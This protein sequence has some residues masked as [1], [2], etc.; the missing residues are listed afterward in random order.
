MPT[1][2]RYRLRISWP[3]GLPPTGSSS[4][5]V[6]SAADV[7]DGSFD[8]AE[9]ADRVVF[10]GVTDPTLGD[11]VATPISKG[12][13]DPG[14]MVQAAAFHT[15]ASRQFVAEPSTPATLVWVAVLTLLVALAVQFLPLP[16]AGLSSAVLLVVAVLG[17]ILRAADGTPLHS[18]YP[19]MAVALAIPLSGGLRYFT[20]T[21]ARRRVAA[22]FARYV[23]P[24]VAE[25]LTR[26]GRLDEVAEGQRLD[27]SVF[28]CDLR[29]FTPLSAS[30]EPT[31][32]NRILSRYYEYVSAAVLAE[33]G[34]IIQYVGDEVFAVFGAPLARE[35]HASA[36]LRVAFAVQAGRTELER[37]LQDDGL[38]M[39]EFGIGINSGEV[40]AV[41][42]GST[43]RRQYAVVGDTVNVGA[44][45]C[46]EAREGQV[47]AADRAVDAAPPLPGGEPYHPTLKGVERDIVVWR[48]TPE[49]V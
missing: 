17:P 30:L 36:A 6:I 46:S 12:T 37:Q 5:P 20:E 10:I 27:I 9:V 33:D 3:D 40:V 7:L 16:L 25:E 13:S 11:Q 14:V 42:A 18:L 48:F 44:R 23:P 31:Q 2:D 29:G 45:L 4:G 32:V 38:P 1:D 24:P 41:H 34:T 47:V 19:A 49:P 26:E 35:D 22:L 15:M 8:P 43:F 28:F 21:R 39:V